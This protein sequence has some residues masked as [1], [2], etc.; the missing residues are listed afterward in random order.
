LH[1]QELQP[2]AS[3]APA[4]SGALPA[5]PR[6]APPPAERHLAYSPYEN[7]TIEE[8]LGARREVQ[9]L[10]PEGKTVESVEIVPLDVFERRDLPDWGSPVVLPVT[11]VLHATTRP[12]VIRREV[13]LREGGLYT[14]AL[15][16]DTIRNLR[17]IPG[18]PQLSLVLV[19]A[20]VGSSPDRVRVVV[21]TKD[22]WSLRVNWNA[23]A[24]T[25][26]IEQIAFEPSENNFLG[27]HQILGT[28]FVLEPATYTFGLG[29]TV[30][31]VDASRVAMVGAGN[32][33]VNRDS[34]RAE[35]SYGSLIAGQPL[36][37]GRA[38]WSWDS[39]VAWRDVI[40]RRYVNAAQSY[41]ADEAGKVPFAFRERTF[42]A[43][44]EVT[45]SFG[46]EVKHDITAAAFVTR[47]EYLTN[48]DGQASAPKATLANFVSTEV[49]VDDARVG[50]AL[51]YHSY[52]TR[53]VRVFDADTLALQEDYRLGHD[54][55]ARVYPSFV[56][57]DLPD[58]ANAVYGTYLGAQY[59]WAVRDGIFRVS[60]EETTEFEPTRI[61]D[62]AFVPSV[63][64]V[65][66][67]IG[68]IGRFVL[69]GTLL[70]RWR[71][72]LRQTT[73]LGGDDR[74]R[75][76]PTN[77]F[78]GQNA[79]AYNLEFRTRPVEI[80]SCEVGLVA[81]Y[82]IG[83]AANGPISNLHPY[84]AVGA[85]VRALFPWLDRVV[86]R[87]DLGVPLQHPYADLVAPPTISP[88]GFVIT[89]AQAFDTPTIAQPPVLP[90]GQAT[91]AP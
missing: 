20:A 32:V 65:S 62:A 3:T 77:F 54:F 39:N 5:A 12:Y 17:R 51:Q 46:W 27:T 18:L 40:Y 49:P 59:S 47:G 41:F 75:G 30:P 83:D 42:A 4:P 44:Y 91:D 58:R 29:Y 36:S 60:L 56:R 43:N 72:Y 10:S 9:D 87:A 73:T 90:T 8:V 80:L 66:P 84:Q 34:G 79:F 21:I 81:F 82:D 11:S 2:A 23:V 89:F 7:E 57:R 45:R 1:A 76:Y 35:G 19:V 69:D 86:F 68:T 48:V 50:P 88:V 63:H 61:S 67:S 71:N 24:T 28:L 38:E 55:I 52:T 25:G 37:S 26:G 14:Q 15:V 78:V 64:F 31:S 33:M 6:G 70:W 53:F 16:D 13:L 74:V 85:G 22:V